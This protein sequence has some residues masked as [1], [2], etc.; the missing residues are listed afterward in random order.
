MVGLSVRIAAYTTGYLHIQVNPKL[1]YSTSK[2]IK[3]AE[4]KWT[5][6][7]PLYTKPH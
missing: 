6:Q 3:N 7:L 2:I 5:E 4:R 1:S